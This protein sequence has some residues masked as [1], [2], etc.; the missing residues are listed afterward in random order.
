MLRAVELCTVFMNSVYTT[1]ANKKLVQSW[2]LTQ[3]CRTAPV[4]L[5]CEASKSGQW[6][7]CP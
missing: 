7:G 3:A 5:E 2:I 4:V 1:V 6:L